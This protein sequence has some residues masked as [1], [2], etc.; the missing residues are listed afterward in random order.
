MRR[1][2]TVVAAQ[3]EIDAYEVVANAERHAEVVAEAAAD[4][5]VFPELSLTGYQLDAAPVALSD[6]RLSP[7][8]DACAATG[9]L[10]LVGAPVAAPGGGR[11]IATLAIDGSGAGVAYR[12]MWLG[13]AEAELFVAGD[14]PAVISRSGWRIGL[15]ICKDTGVAEQA[16]ATMAKGCDLYI[17]GSLEHA[18]DADVLPRRA[19]AIATRHDVWVI[20]ASYAGSAG[21]GYDVAA[22]GSG[23]W[24]PDGS[25]VVRAGWAPNDVARATIDPSDI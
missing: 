10:A 20:I 7:I 15:A 24:R 11:S 4:V 8:V 6:E 1:A 5:V 21:G 13:E 2:L 17:A 3:P 23:I 18:N 25:V 12:K 19:R 9:S 14:S 16:M 22:G